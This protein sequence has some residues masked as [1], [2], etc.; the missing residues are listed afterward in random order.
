MAAE[1]TRPA[2]DV[3]V[4]TRFHQSRMARFIRW[5]DDYTLWAFNPPD[6]LAPGG[7]PTRRARADQPDDPVAT[8]RDLEDRRSKVDKHL[9]DLYDESALAVRMLRR[10]GWSFGR[11]AAETGIT[12]QRVAQLARSS[13][14]AG[15]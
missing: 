1:V 8:L 5:A 2:T 4:P 6:V 7:S 12:N 14:G 10:R 9:E 15:R 11:I 3:D 13:L